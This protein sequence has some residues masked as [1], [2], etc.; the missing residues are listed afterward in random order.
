M[1]SANVVFATMTGNNEEV[2][3]LVCDALTREGIVVNE[4]EISQTE[5]AE[6]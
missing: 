6:F 3:D 1:V 5:C 4:T 2:A